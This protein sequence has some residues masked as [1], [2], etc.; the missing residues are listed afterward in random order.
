M[1]QV[2]PERASWL[3]IFD[4][5]DRA[6]TLK[7]FWPKE[8][9]GSVLVTCRDPLIKSSIYLRNTRVFLPELLE[10]EGIALLLRLTSRANDENNIK[11]APEA[12]RA[13][14]RYP[15]AIA[16]ISGVILARD[17]TF[18]EFL[19]LYSEERKRRNIL[20]ISEGQSASL[21]R[22][23]QTLG[24]VW[25][26]DDLKEGR[27]LLDV[28]S[29]IDP[30]SIPESL[31]ESNPACIDLDRYPKTSLEYTKARAELLSRSLIYRNRDKK[32]LRIHRLI[33]D[34]TRTQ[35]DDTIFNEVYSRVLD[36]LDARW[37]KA[38]K[39]F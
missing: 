29:F 28:I 26:L 18:N 31:L 23:N 34:T 24:T 3:I 33:Q 5:V 27:A 35:M 38:F 22:Y 10:E 19:D 6:D 4:N 13:L 7:E 36:M 25:A 11:Q 30:D 9:A 14:D 39:G 12:I 8:A 17:L 16:Q 21:R 15:L 1:D 20:G 37:P 32:T 2:K